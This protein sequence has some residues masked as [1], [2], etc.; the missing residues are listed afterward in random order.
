LGG[1]FERPCGVYSHLPSPQAV[2][3]D[4]RCCIARHSENQRMH[5]RVLQ[6]MTRWLVRMA[7]MA[8]RPVGTPRQRADFRRQASMP[9]LW[10]MEA[11]SLIAGAN[12]LWQKYKA[13]SRATFPSPPRR[14]QRR[15]YAGDVQPWAAMMFDGF[16]VENLSKGILL[17]QGT[18]AEQGGRLDQQLKTHNLTALCTRAGITL[19]RDEEELLER[20]GRMLETW[21][22]SSR[23]RRHNGP[24]THAG[25][26]T[27]SQHHAWHLAARGC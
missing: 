1:E 26:A 13:R 21:T 8:K 20:T 24:P 19:S 5:V 22:L 2:R 18:N 7:S 17:A 3:D 9:W 6:R 10:Q 15:W 16:A 4:F 11:H 12:V 25:L 14:V 27:R 23:C